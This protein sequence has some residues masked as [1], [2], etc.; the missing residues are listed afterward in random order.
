MLSSNKIK[1]AI[2]FGTLVISYYLTLKVDA[3]E[4]ELRYNRQMSVI[5]NTIEHPYKYRV[6]NPLCIQAY[7]SVFNHF[8]PERPAFLL[9]CALQNIICFLFLFYASSRFFSLWFDDTG[10]LIGLLLIAL[11]MPLALTW[12]DVLGDVVTAGLMALGFY[13]I[14]TKK[15]NLI[16]PILVIGALNELQII[17]LILFYFFGKKDNFKSGKVWLKSVLF[18]IIFFAAYALLYWLRGGQTDTDSSTW[19]ERRDFDYNLHHLQFVLVWGV[20]VLPLLYFTV[21]N[22]KSKPEFLRLNLF[23]VIPVFYV[24]VFSLIARLVEIDKALT[25]FLILIPLALHSLIPAHL[26]QNKSQT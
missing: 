17:L 3:P 13:F 6:L 23:T 26:L 18:V 5:H 15:E 2:L 1:F 25:M 21:K 10:V 12:W 4:F 24:I 20:L 7:Y 16:F 19:L 22:L 14:N 9:A 8:I 11:I